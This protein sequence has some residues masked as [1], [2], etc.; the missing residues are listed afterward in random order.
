[1][2][3]I[4]PRRLSKDCFGC[5]QKFKFIKSICVNRVLIYLKTRFIEN[6]CQMFL[7]FLDK[8][9]HFQTFFQTLQGADGSQ[10]SLISYY[11]S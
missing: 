8:K 9:H 2:D 3:L 5:Y 1:M 6:F 4:Q 7:G 10:F 11:L